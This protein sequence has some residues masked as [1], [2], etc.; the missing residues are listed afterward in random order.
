MASK[1]KIVLRLALL[2]GAIYLGYKYKDKIVGKVGKLSRMDNM[3]DVLSDLAR[4]SDKAVDGIIEGTEDFYD[5]ILTLLGQEVEY[6]PNVA[7]QRELD[8]A[9]KDLPKGVV[10]NYGTLLKTYA[11]NLVR[12]IRN[13]DNELFDYQSFVNWHNY[14]SLKGQGDF[15]RVTNLI[16]IMLQYKAPF[17][18]EHD[19]V[20]DYSLPT[21][22]RY[23]SNPPQRFIELDDVDWKKW[24]VDCKGDCKPPMHY[25]LT[26]RSLFRVIGDKL[27]NEG[28]VGSA[29]RKPIDIYKRR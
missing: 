29:S 28:L 3:D 14:F 27:R 17:E 10:T 5:Y 8:E 26:P 2:G 6:K 16:N 23:V 22:D 19:T 15:A 21:L 24:R 1:K 11:S 13:W 18:L 9:V 25:S 4:T 12:D 7:Y 20:R